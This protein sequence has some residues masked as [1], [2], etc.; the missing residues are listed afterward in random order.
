M[1]HLITFL[2]GI[3]FAQLIIIKNSP[4]VTIVA[5]AFMLLSLFLL[6]AHIQ[7]YDLSFQ[8]VSNQFVNLILFFMLGI[9]ALWVYFRMYIELNP[10]SLHF[11]IIILIFNAAS[12]FK[13]ISKNKI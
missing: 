10:K 9:T 3:L 13:R 2:N 4:E 11:W 1:Y 6:A 7:S 8:T 5:L 12:I